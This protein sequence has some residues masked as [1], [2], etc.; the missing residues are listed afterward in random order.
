MNVK[1][2]SLGCLKNIYTV[3]LNVAAVMLDITVAIETV[4]LIF[5]C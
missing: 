1:L 2:D 3:L 5:R 4:I